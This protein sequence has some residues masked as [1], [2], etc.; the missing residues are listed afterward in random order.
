M[1]SWGVYM[2]TLEKNVAIAKSGVYEYGRNEIVRMLGITQDAIP[3]EHS[4]LAYFG[5]YRPAPVLAAS[6]SKFTKLPAVLEHPGEAIN[7]SNFREYT[8]GWTGDSAF[9]EYIS[10]SDEVIIRS[11]LN[12]I[13]DEA[14]RAYRSGIREVSP[15]YKAEFKWSGGTAPDG[16]K[17]Q[18]IMDSI[19]SVNHLAM[20][21]AARG[22]SD[23]SILDSRSYNPAMY[24]I[25]K[26]MRMVED[27]DLGAFRD[28]IEYLMTNRAMVSDKDMKNAIEDFMSMT[29]DLPDTNE[30]A[31]LIRHLQDL[32]RLKDLD[33]E[34]AKQAGAVIADLY[35]KLDADAMGDVVQSEDS[36]ALFFG[37]GKKPL[38]KDAEPPVEAEKKPD[39]APAE[40]AP[41]PEAQAPAAEAA[42]PAATEAPAEGAPVAEEQKTMTIDEVPESPDQMDESHVKYLLGELRALLAANRPQAAAEAPAEGMPAAAT[43]G[44][45]EGDKPK[46]SYTGDSKLF[47]S[48]TATMSAARK[49]DDILAS[50]GPIDKKRGK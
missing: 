36:M 18:I 48:S 50:I 33:D 17:Y 47:T 28:N 40:A 39:E 22:G 11:S 31:Q 32:P 41:A 27:S 46:T 3:S 10:D 15:G 16:K 4:G 44:M 13:D 21:R 45:T 34:S 5:V 6:V 30:K 25:K 42:P 37:K 29:K 43:D 2:P 49:A 35:E 19:E 24:A 23:T 26:F 14:V 1:H 7:G 12:L 38:T 8:L 9:A 20:T